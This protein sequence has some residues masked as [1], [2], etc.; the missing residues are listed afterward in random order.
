MAKTVGEE[1]NEKPLLVVSKL[2]SIFSKLSGL[3]IKQSV[4]SENCFSQ[5]SGRVLYVDCNEFSFD[6]IFSSSEVLIFQI[7]N[8][9]FS[10]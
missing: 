9:K 1:N 3:D 5:S 2:A 8:A 7:S 10:T 4:D 6:F